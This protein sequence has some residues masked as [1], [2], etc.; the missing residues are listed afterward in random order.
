MEA[1]CIQEKSMKCQF[2]LPSV[3]LISHI[4]GN[5]KLLKLHIN[6]IFPNRGTIRIVYTIVSVSTV[7]MLE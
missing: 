1:N 4:S 6:E 7:N 2:Q 3:D 5:E